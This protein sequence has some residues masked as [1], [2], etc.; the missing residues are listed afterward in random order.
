M[1]RR[2]VWI[3][4]GLAAFFAVLTIPAVIW[5]AESVLFVILL[6]LATQI[7]ASLSASEAADDR[8]ITDRLDRIEAL[9]TDGEGG[10]GRPRP[11]H[12]VLFGTPCWSGNPQVASR[13]L[14]ERAS[15]RQRQQPL[16]ADQ[17]R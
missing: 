17:V 7:S 11:D 2:K 12:G 8:S 6:S 1:G 3:H 9:L 16:P 10:H 14:R 4:R 13:R 15:G 5:W